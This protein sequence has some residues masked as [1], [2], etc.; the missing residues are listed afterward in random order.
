MQQLDD[1]SNAY[2]S[3]LIAYLH[4][5]LDLLVKGNKNDAR[6]IQCQR[7]QGLL[8]MTKLE[9]ISS[10]MRDISQVPEES[11]C[12][13]GMAPLL[14]IVASETRDADEFAMAAAR[15]NRLQETARLGNLKTA[16]ELLGKIK[17]SNG[18]DWRQTLR[19]CNWDLI[20]S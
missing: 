11:H 6:I 15:L 3:V 12:A 18:T 17:H 14:F 19:A 16:W 8:P 20:V 4:A 1:V 7:I 13:I 10:C 2:R 5:I 9:A